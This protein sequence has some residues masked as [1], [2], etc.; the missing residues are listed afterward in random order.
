MAGWP[1]ENGPPPALNCTVDDVATPISYTQEGFRK[2]LNL[3]MHGALYLPSPS[4]PSLQKGMWAVYQYDDPHILYKGLWRPRTV[5]GDIGWGATQ[6]GSSLELKFTGSRV[7][8]EGG[9]MVPYYT[10]SEFIQLQSLGAYRIDDGE[11]RSFNPLHGFNQSV[12]QTGKRHALILLTN[13]ELSS[14]DHA[15]TLVTD[16]NINAALPEPPIVLFQ[17]LVEQ[18]KF[19]VDAESETISSI[20]PTT[21]TLSSP[22]PLASGPSPPVVSRGVSTGTI[23]GSA[24]GGFVGLVI[25]ALALLWDRRRKNLKR[26]RGAGFDSHIESFPHTLPIPAPLDQAPLQRKGK[27]AHVVSSSPNN[28]NDHTQELLGPENSLRQHQDSVVGIRSDS[29]DLPPD[30]TPTVSK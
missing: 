29:E 26:Q 18:G 19:L 16:A 28:P 22:T 13:E 8:W 2:D 1:P 25:L 6:N 14:G 3:T 10:E 4:N 24:I 20:V 5:E 11:P 27:Q 17:L 12:S 9:E 30:Y 15:I 21:S 7:V 23:V